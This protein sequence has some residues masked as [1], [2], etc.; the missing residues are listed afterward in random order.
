MA[1]WRLHG[2]EK[3][4]KHAELCRSIYEPPSERWDHDHCEFCGEKF[5]VAEGDHTE[6]YSTLDRDHWICEACYIDFKV[7]FDWKIIS[8]DEISA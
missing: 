8:E 3:Y 2:Q 4:L 5:A 1:D 7:E 6:G